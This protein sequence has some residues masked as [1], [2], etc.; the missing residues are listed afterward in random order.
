[1]INRDVRLCYAIRISCEHKCP[2]LTSG[3]I[4]G[5]NQTCDV[6][7]RANFPRANRIKANT[8]Y[9]KHTEDVVRRVPV[10]ITTDSKE[11]LVEH[12][13]INQGCVWDSCKF[14]ERTYVGVLHFAKLQSSCHCVI[15]ISY[16]WKHFLDFWYRLPY[17]KPHT[18][19]KCKTVARSRADFR[20]EQKT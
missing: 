10:R 5:M 3:R 9:R 6:I 20:K 7:C 14:R 18:Q 17:I 12:Q 4:P 15:W 13:H 1:M 11:P 8:K 19:V 2:N 16:K